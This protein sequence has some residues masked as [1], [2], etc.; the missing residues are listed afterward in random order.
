MLVSYKG[1]IIVSLIVL[2]LDGIIVYYNNYYFNNLNIFYP[3][4]TISLIPFLFDNNQKE[5]YKICFIIGIIY[6]LLYSNIFLYNGF[7]FLLLSKID[8]KI[9]KYLK[10]NLFL[11]MM[12]VIIN[13]IFYD[14]ISFL[15]IKVTNYQIVTF[16]D[17]IYKIENSLL[18]NIMSS[19]VFFFLVKKK[20]GYHKM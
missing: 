12:L 10:N 7:L 2:I 3:M 14:T 1:K 18:L 11:Y 16:S 20:M 6:D 19:F 9:M 4:L 17:L 13:I 5:Y 8:V 15:L